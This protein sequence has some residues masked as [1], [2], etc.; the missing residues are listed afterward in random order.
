M[1]TRLFVVL[2]GAVSLLG[3]GLTACT[4][5]DTAG[6]GG[7]GGSGGTG[8]TATTTTTS[9]GTGGAGG[10]GGEG[11]GG[12]GGGA[13]VTCGEA[14][15]NAVD[16]FCDADSE[17]LYDAFFGCLCDAGEPCVDECGDNQCMDMAASPDCE[18]CI[19]DSVAGCKAQSDACVNDT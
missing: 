13:C 19:Q 15:D 7:S 11:T 4:T 10:A 8:G 3:L 17:A 5:D 18:T 1:K 14:L 2:A 12:A 9:N 16:P 6:T